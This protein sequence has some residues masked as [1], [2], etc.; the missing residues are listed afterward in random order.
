MV[1][2][3]KI[4]YAFVGVLTVAMLA[5]SIAQPFMFASDDLLAYGSIQADGRGLP[6]DD[7][8]GAFLVLN[9]PHNPTY[10]GDL[11]ELL[12]TTE[13]GVVDEHAGAHFLPGEVKSV[14]VQTA[15][16]NEN[17]DYRVYRFNVEEN[18]RMKYTRA[19]SGKI[20]YIENTNAAWEPG[21]YIIDIPSEGMFGGRTYYQ[22]YVD[23]S[24]PATP[25]K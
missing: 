9:E 18:Q 19:P 13:A 4:G 11:V 23:S 6:A 12:A 24:T 17:S 22:F 21:T 1:L 20:M 15:A 10:V 5:L 3:R 7:K 14:L 8:R 2:A 16:L 25:T